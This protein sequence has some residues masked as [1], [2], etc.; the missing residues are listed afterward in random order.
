MTFNQKI[1]LLNLE[2]TDINM[3]IVNLKFQFRELMNLIRNLISDDEIIENFTHCQ[4]IVF[5][6]YEK[7]IID[8][9]IAKFKW[10]RN[11]YYNY[12][13]NKTVNKDWNKNLSSRD[14][15]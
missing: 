1:N 5:D 9:S 13:L 12:Q 4:K 14:I 8:K 11:K 2:I 10:L 3:T 6:K 15:P 7:Q